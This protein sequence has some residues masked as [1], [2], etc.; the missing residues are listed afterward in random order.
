MDIITYSKIPAEYRKTLSLYIREK[1]LAYF[2]ILLYGLKYYI[3]LTVGLK[4]LLRIKK[5]KNNFIFPSYK[6]ERLL[7]DFLRT[8]VDSLYLQ[9][10]DTVGT[11]VHRE[12]DS[13]LRESFS[14]LF[15]NFLVK[16]VESKMNSSQ[17]KSLSF[18]PNKSK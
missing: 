2:I 14:K 18:H 4:K 5:V 3:P 15:E 12:L 6:A 1:A 13:E 8:V 9:V 16:K 10:R 17:Y 11:E 7:E